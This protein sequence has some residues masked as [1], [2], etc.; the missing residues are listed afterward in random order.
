MR[1]HWM[2][3]AVLV[4][5]LSL[6]AG[7]AVATPAQ[8]SP[9][10][11]APTSIPP[12]VAPTA[13]PAPPPPA[14]PTAQPALTAQ[15]TSPASA[16]GIRGFLS[17]WGSSSGDVFVT[18][19]EGEPLAGNDSGRAGRILHYDGNKW[20]P[21]SA[22]E[23]DWLG[24]IWGSSASDVFASGYGGTI[25]HYD[26]RTWSLM[27]SGTSRTL[28][29]LWGSSASEV[30]AVGDSGT[31]LHYDGSK[32]SR[33]ESGVDVG[34]QPTYSWLIGVWG[35]SPND[36]FAVGDRGIIV[37]YDGKTWS[38]MESHSFKDLWGVWGSSGKDVFA[39]GEPGGPILHFDGND[40]SDMK[41]GTTYELMGVWGTSSSDVF[42]VGENG[43][44]LHYD[45]NLW[46]PM[47]SGVTSY[48]ESAWGS[49]ASDIFVVGDEN[50][51]GT[52]LH[53][54]GSMWSPMS[55]GAPA[56][57][58]AAAAPAVDLLALIK[59][60]QDAYNRH[61]V[62]A[63]AG[64]F[65]DKGCIDWGVVPKCGSS[66]LKDL[67]RYDAALN[68]QLEISDCIVED[69]HVTCNAAQRNDCLAAGGL[70]E[71][72][73]APVAFLFQ[74]GKIALVTATK[75]PEDAQ[76]DLLFLYL[77]AGWS[78]R[79][80]PAEWDKAGRQDLLDDRLSPTFDNDTG[81]AMSALCKEYAS[82]AAATTPN[83]APAPPQTPPA[84]KA[85]GRVLFIG[86]SSSLGLDGLL[87]KL[88]ASGQPSV[89][90]TSKLN[91]HPGIAFGGQY[92]LGTALEDIRQGQWDVVVLQD[93]L[94]MDWPGRA[95]EFYEY[96]RKFDQAIKQAGAETVFYMVYPYRDSK[97]TTTEEI[98][99]AYSKIGKDLGDKVAPVALA[100]N[101]SL[102]ERPDLDLYALDGE[103]PSWAGIYLEDCVLYATIFG[104]SPVG[105]P[106][107][108][109]G[110]APGDWQIS[111][112]L[113][114]TALLYLDGANW[115]ISEQ[116][117]ADLQR[118]AWETVQDYQAGR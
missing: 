13:P 74:N 25:M 78:H 23:T 64:L 45:G 30:F 10:Q 9:P 112:P 102:K 41:S 91:W 63:T 62:D 66:E 68:S 75:M 111:S 77:L 85:P 55:S 79:T 38:R 26:G 57:T 89:T 2:R 37:H 7:C 99:A 19:Y 109:Q 28:L 12:A 59:A 73:Y 52:I 115:Q 86:D 11:P 35:S 43:T 100:F 101:R 107:R 27:E 96:G 47:N 48:F 36:V 56:A 117:A 113:E 4:I 15:P 5:V 40:W 81:A 58:A 39:V 87:P 42:V 29:G 108:M 51:V 6:V 97:V 67:L 16:Q 116:D 34:S 24:N 76:R 93:D 50:A 82:V 60:Y 98:A 49:S 106:Y 69:D 20:S 3:L 14:E 114:Q 53:Y 118:I 61:D 72:H 31:I 46:S 94:N 1:A 80:R 21:M 104:R 92:E 83:P 44:I 71:T 90:M 103:H 105:L 110:L 84:T 88:A 33:M 54:D 18:G 8:P 95:A 65:A 32:W 17:V 22:P 70:G